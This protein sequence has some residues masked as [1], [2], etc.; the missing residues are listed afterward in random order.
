MIIRYS[1]RSVCRRSRWTFCLSELEWWETKWLNVSFPFML[2][3]SVISLSSAHEFAAASLSPLC[4]WSHQAPLSRLVFLNVSE[5]AGQRLFTITLSHITYCTNMF[6]HSPFRAPVQYWRFICLV[7]YLALLF[8]IFVYYYICLVLYINS[9]YLCLLCVSYL[10]LFWSQIGR[11]T[12]FL[13]CFSALQC[14]YWAVSSKKH[15]YPVKHMIQSL[16]HDLFLL[17]LPGRSAI[18]VWPHLSQRGW[19]TWWRE[20]TST[21]FIL[22]IVRLKFLPCWYF[23]EKL[24]LMLHSGAL[25]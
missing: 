2:S 17:V 25:F 13:F 23:C 3:F 14:C 24:G 7:F 6:I 11:R 1:F 20:W 18:L 9:Y 19:E 8:L 15:I 4:Q 16:K 12:N 5:I 21:D 22:T 10:V